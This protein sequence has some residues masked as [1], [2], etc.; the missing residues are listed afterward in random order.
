[1]ASEASLAIYTL[2]YNV[3]VNTIRYL[4]LLTYVFVDCH[5]KTHLLLLLPLLILLYLLFTN[6][7]A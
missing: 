2:W 4:Y 3:V 7:V 1:M 5:Y 6:K